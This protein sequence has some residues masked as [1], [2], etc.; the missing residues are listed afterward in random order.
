[1]RVYLVSDI[2][3]AL[4]A[5]TERARSELERRIP[6]AVIS[7]LDD[8]GILVKGKR[9]LDLGAGLGGMSEE[10]LLSGAHGQTILA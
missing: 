6:K 5:A 4:P 3:I 2:G 10:L 8:K 1:M 9:V 7:Q